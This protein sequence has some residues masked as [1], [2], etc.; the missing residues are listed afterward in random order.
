MQWFKN[1]QIYRLNR[2][3]VLEAAALEKQLEPMRYL[4]CGSQDMS[5]MGW[6]SPLGEAS[7][8][9]LHAING[10]LILC[11]QTEEKILPGPVVKQAHQAKISK[12]E[13]AQQRK[14]HKTEK[15]SLKDEVL[16]QLL[17]RAF[18]R[19]RQTWMWIDTTHSLIMV[20]AASSKRAEE[21]LA[22]LRKCTGSLPVTPLSLENP[23]ALT[24]TDWLR[25]QNLPEGFQLM[26]EAELK[27][28]LEEGGVI[29]CKKQDLFSDEIHSHIAA[30]KLVTR[31]AL[32]W[33]ERILFTLSEEGAVTKLKYGETLR[34][35]NEDIDKEDIAQRFD[36]DALLLTGEL[37]L[38]ISELIEA[39]GGESER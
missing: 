25:E 9:L 23:I 37:T 21:M 34:E 24:L 6:L 38:L 12:L 36:A 32:E 22:L 35:Q 28:L 3:I 1:L 13:A 31:L 39:L 33:R 18:S 27:S 8:S 5:K 7:D 20:D 14:L 17:P 4:P 11:A 10:Q 30:G 16:Q 29:R 2:D 26:D 19:F 15:D